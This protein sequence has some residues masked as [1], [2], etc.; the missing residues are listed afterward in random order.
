M[1]KFY[2][3]GARGGQTQVFMT[4]YDFVAV[5]PQLNIPVLQLNTLS[6]MP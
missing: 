5:A 2:N 6:G 1:K 3:H 4:V